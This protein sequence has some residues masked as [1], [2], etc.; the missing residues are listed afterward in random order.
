MNKVSEK[1]VQVLEYMC[2]VS[3]KPEKVTRGAHGKIINVA[4]ND[5]F[6]FLIKTSLT[7]YY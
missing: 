2:K 1:S 4:W 5:P 3:A 7:R 6:S